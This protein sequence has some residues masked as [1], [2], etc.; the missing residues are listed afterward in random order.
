MGKRKDPIYWVVVTGSS[1]EGHAGIPME[2]VSE[3]VRAP[4]YIRQ[5][6][7]HNTAL[8][9]RYLRREADGWRGVDAVNRRLSD[10]LVRFDSFDAMLVYLRCADEVVRQHV[11]ELARTKA[12]RKK[13]ERALQRASNM[14]YAV[15][16][17]QHDAQLTLIAGLGGDVPDH[18]WRNPKARP[19]AT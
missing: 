16:S 7:E 5:S 10:V 19:K 6:T 1:R 4:K 13:A 12:I 14:H 18:Q 3:R 9:G 17:D 8:Y 11:V 2:V 15:A